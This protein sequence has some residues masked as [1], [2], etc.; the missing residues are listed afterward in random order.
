M[1]AFSV[2]VFSA[3]VGHI[4]IPPAA[5]IKTIGA[6]IF[7]APQWSQN[8]EVLHRTV[9]ME[10]RLPRIITAGAVGGALALSGAV[11]QGVLQ[12]PLADPYTLG[13]SAGAAL[14]ASAAIL[15]NIAWGGFSV[16]LLAFIGALSTLLAVIHLSYSAGGLSPTR[17][18]LS[19][20][21]VAAIL[22]AGV[23]FLKYL[24]DEQVAVIIFWLMGGFTSRTWA[25]AA[26]ALS[27]MGAGWLVFRF[28]ADELNIL[29]LGERSAASMGVNMRRTPVILLIIASLIAAV[30]VSVSTAGS[31]LDLWPPGAHC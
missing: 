19:G 9:I 15:L 31:Y 6:K 12:N 11:F 10:V 18:I 25:H 14:G 8:I 13:V 5:V 3:S 23:S 26:A 4:D 7:D 30:C 20:V 22:S 24:A 1:F 17:L 29:S 2:V 28:Y 27:A 16:P 21:I